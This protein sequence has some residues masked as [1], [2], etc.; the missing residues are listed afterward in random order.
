MQKLFAAIGLSIYVLLGFYPD[1]NENANVNTDNV[2]TCYG[3][4]P[5]NACSNCSQCR[6]CS[7]GGT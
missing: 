1:A 6:Y 7:K 5:C 2:A 4:T 3:Y